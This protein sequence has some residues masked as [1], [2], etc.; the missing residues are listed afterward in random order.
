L[1]SFVGWAPACMSEEVDVQFGD[2]RRKE[3]EE[4]EKKLLKT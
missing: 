3:E 1:V 2:I 4:S